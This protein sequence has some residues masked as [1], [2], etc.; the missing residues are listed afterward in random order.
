MPIAP[1]PAEHLRWHVPDGL[2]TFT[3]TAELPPAEAF[4]GQANAIAALRRGVELHAPGFNVFVAG[5]PSTGRLSAVER[6]VKSFAPRRRSARDLVYVCNVVDP[7]RPRLLTF[8]AGRGLAFRRELMRVAAVLLE[9]VPRLLGVGEVRRQREASTHGAAATSHAALQKLRQRAEQ[10]G[11]VVGDVGEGDDVE[12]VLF[13]VEPGEATGDEAPVHT[14]AE[15]QVL[16]EGGEITLPRPLQDILADFDA[17]SQELAEA[18]DASRRAVLETVRAVAQAEAE[19]LASGTAPIFAELGRRWPAA[20]AWIVDLHEALV[21]SPEWFDEESGHAELLGAFTANVVHVGARAR[22]API[23]VVPNPTWQHMFG[24]IEST[25]GAPSDHRAIRT[26]ALADADGGFVVLSANELLQEPSTWKVLKRALMFGETDIQN[27]GDGAGSPSVLR[28]DPL[29]LDVKVVLVGDAESYALLYYGDPDFG[30]LFKIKAEFE[31]DALISA[32][33]LHGC[34]A[35]IARVVRREGLL[36]LTRDAVGATLEWAVREAGRGGR[37]ST[38]FG[39]MADVVREASFEAKAAGAAVVDRVHIDAARQARRRRDDFA[40]RRVSELVDGEVV[41]VDVSGAKVA[42]VNALVVYHVGGHDFGRPVRLTATVGAGRRGVVSLERAA[43]LSGRSH[44][45]GFGIVQGI[46]LDKFGREGRLTFAGM[47]SFEQ[48]YVKVDGDSA[49][50]AEVLVFLSALA[51]LP[52][53][54]DVAVTGS[55]DQFGEIQAVGG[56]NEKIEGFWQTCR[57]R[58][59]TGTQGVLVPATNVADLCLEAEVQSACA[60][61][62][63]RVWPARTLEDAVE[64]LFGMPAGERDARGRWT[65]GSVFARVA[66]ALDAL[67][68][69]TVGGARRRPARA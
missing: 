60:D 55:L 20:R 36:P 38:H 40:E 33:L 6:I 58:G 44:D 18:Q 12:P 46:L 65:A 29:R 31:P 8:P 28:P 34:A 67:R 17:L 52:L 48:S 14:R 50:L 7:G 16:A 45:K 22:K 54:Q 56:V 59:L 37:I 23:V 4:V 51:R 9:E 42:Q 3:T 57:P 27:P 63:F 26:G 43:R 35:F 30:K 62:T 13:W 39:S 32:E 21:D 1:L 25:E 19:A 47:L 53:R 61:G 49:T 11:F 41:R 64:L 15:L 10:L 5:L 24:G 2:F 69:A 68:V 66:E